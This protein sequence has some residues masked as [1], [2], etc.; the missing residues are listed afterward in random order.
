MAPALAGACQQLVYGADDIDTRPDLVQPPPRGQKI[1]R[2]WHILF[3]FM[4]LL[5]SQAL[6]QFTRT[7]SSSNPFPFFSPLFSV[8]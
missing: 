5:V 1:I 7:T 6:T 2:V 8:K 4:P 3:V